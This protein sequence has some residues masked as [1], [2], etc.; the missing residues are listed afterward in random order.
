MSRPSVIEPQRSRLGPL[1]VTFAEV[2]QDESNYAVLNRAL[3]VLG[4]TERALT[5][6]RAPAPR[7]F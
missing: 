3:R 5:D 7:W 2:S 4:P 1:K 6:P